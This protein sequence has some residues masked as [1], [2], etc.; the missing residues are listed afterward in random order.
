MNYTLLSCLTYLT[1]MYSV[2]PFLRP[3]HRLAVIVLWP[4]KLVAGALSPLLVIMNTM[5][6]LRG[7]RLRNGRLM[8]TGIIRRVAGRALHPRGHQRSRWIRKRF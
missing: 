3:N 5:G 1:A 7:L 8:G 4:F 6:A 2:L